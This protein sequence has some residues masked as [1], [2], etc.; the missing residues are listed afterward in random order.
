MLMN[1]RGAV[2][3]KVNVDIE[4]RPNVNSQRRITKVRLN[5]HLL[6]QVESCVNPTNELP[7]IRPVAEVHLGERLG[8]SSGKQILVV[9][10]VT[11]AALYE[12][13][14]FSELLHATIPIFSS[15]LTHLTRPFLTVI[16]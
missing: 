11:P 14:K 8:R 3:P 2:E 9:I 10:L 7:R 5:I 4:S 1:A 15:N 6:R 16:I 12:P 13:A